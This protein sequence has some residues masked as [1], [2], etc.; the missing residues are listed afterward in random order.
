[1]STTISAPSTTIRRFDRFRSGA[2]YVDSE[3]ADRGAGPRRWWPVAGCLTAYVVLAVVAFFPVGPFDATRLPAAGVGNPAGNDPFQMTWFLTYVPYALTHGLSL[4]HTNFIDYPSGV[5][6]ADNTSVPLLGIL[7]W[8]ITA[9]LGPI[10]AFNFLIRFS[11]AISGASM[12]LVLRRWCSSWQSAFVGGLL[13][14]FGPYM[15]AQ[16]LHIDL[17]F[18]PIPP[19]LLLFGDELVRRQRMSPWRLGLLIGLA[20]TIQLLTSPDIISGCAAMAV[21]I[22]AGLAI[23]FRHLVRQRMGYI[24]KAGALAVG[25]FGLLAAYPVY[26][27]LFGPGSISGPVVP[28]G[29]LQDARADLLGALVPTSNQLL[30]PRFISFIGDYFVGGNL[31]ENGTYIGIPLLIVLIVVLRKL[32]ADATVLVAACAAVFAWV[33]SLGSTLVI[34]TWASP[35]P[36]PG[37]LLAHLPLFDNTIPARYALYVLLFASVVVAIGLDRIWIPQL[38]NLSGTRVSVRERLR[39]LT[40]KQKRL[41]ALGSLVGLSLV[42]NVPFASKEVPWPASLPSTIESVV[43]PGTVVLSVPFP[44]PSNSEAMTWQALAH[45][46]FRIVGGY[47]NIADPGKSHGQRQPIPLPPSHVQEVFSFPK[48]GSLIPWVPQAQAEA[49]LLTYL[50]RYD[51]GAIAFAGM[52]PVTSEGYWYLINTIGQPQIVRPGYAIWLPDHGRWPTK[53]VG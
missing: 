4:F 28:V 41:V 12:F 39:I 15:A 30:V 17:T 34:G 6:L 46:D 48:L 29:L 14:A 19:L 11:L 37:D 22:G 21:A 5:N 18:V 16:E 13:Y 26:E 45:M 23:R 53:P 42:P 44:T 50:R 32:R 27:M 7:A 47:A 40:R 20:S 1:M 2:A 31:S 49:Q 9:T 35:I 51:I 36:L 10:A 52:G 43:A 24:L 38:R 3:G 25:S 8:P 33:L